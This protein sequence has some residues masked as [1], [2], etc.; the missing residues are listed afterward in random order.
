MNGSIQQKVALGIGLVS[1]ILCLA[2]GFIYNSVIDSIQTRNK[3]LQSR[4]VLQD[5]NNI[6][7]DITEAETG[8]RG[9]LLTERPRYL[10]PY[11][12]SIRDIQ[13]NLDDLQLLAKQDSIL[14]KHLK[15]LETAI[16]SKLSELQKSIDLYRT[17][18]K[19]AAMQVVLT[20]EGQKLM[21]EV[22]SRIGQVNDSENILLQSRR[23][24][25]LYNQ[26]VTFVALPV[27]GFIIFFLL[28]LVYWVVSR[29]SV[30]REKAQQELNQLNQV[31]QKNMTLLNSIIE[32]VPGMIFLKDAKELRF[33]LFNKAAEDVVG[34][35]S[36][37]VLGKNDYDFFPKEQADQFTSKDQQTLTLKTL[38]NI[39][40]EEILTKQGHTRILRTKKVPILNEKGD[41]AYL[42]GIS[43]DITEFK[44]TQEHIQ[45]LNHRLEGQVTHLNTLNKELESFSYSVSHDLRAPLRS[46]DGFSQAIL[47]SAEDKLDETEKDYLRRVRTSSQQMAQLID[48]LL[49]LSQVTRAE[50][51]IDLR[52]NLSDIACDI[53][54]ELQRLEPNRH[55]SFEIEEGIIVK[56]DSGLLKVALH[57]LICNAWKFTSK[58]SEAVISFKSYQQE[59]IQVFA[60]HDNGAGFNM[61]YAPKLFEAFQRL[62]TN[63]EF[64][65]TGIGLAIVQKIITRHRGKIWAE[66]Q[67]DHGA[68]FYFTL[69]NVQQEEA[70]SDDA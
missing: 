47:E 37:E 12:T 27:S 14:S 4:Q 2:I 25:N 33:Q 8:Q 11:T 58:Q 45:Q 69:G 22:R 36:E 57:N 67:V 3:V 51:N 53:A 70:R 64:P 42:L 41:S 49:N 68:T 63:K 10:I 54:T 52:V 34:F 43:Q 65:G 44:R 46:I 7:V 19:D 59:D 28:G 61:A 32:N 35:S 9:Y 30:Q 26:Q 48:D 66:G 23:Q 62:H 5:L 31:L 16:H 24:Q 20:D 55:V 13:H 15:L 50:L 21:E 56:G 60:L 17:K 18:G 1:F 39:E 29:E 6:L 38:V 40:E